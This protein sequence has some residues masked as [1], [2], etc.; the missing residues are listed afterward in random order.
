MTRPKVFAMSRSID[1][2]S[3][4]PIQAG[5]VMP[6][7]QPRRFD[8]QAYDGGP[9]PVAG[10]DLPVIVDLA[11][12]EL[13]EAMPLLIDHE[14]T[15][16]ATLGSTD[17]IENNGQSMRIA[18][19]VTATS[20][21][22]VGVVDQFDKGQRW[23][24]SIGVRVGVLQEIQAGQIVVVNKQSFRGPVLVA[25]HSQMFETSVLPAGA[26]WT[27]TVN[28]AA[29]AARLLKG[30][31]TM[32]TF[33][34]WLASL[35]VD[36]AGLDDNSR[37]ALTLGYDAMQN[38]QPTPPPT[39]PVAVPAGAP[40]VNQPNQ[41]PM[42]QV[43]ASALADIRAKFDADMLQS[44]REKY[45][46]ESERV[47]KIELV[48]AAF[49]LIKATAVRE[50]WD[51][52]KTENAVLKEQAKTKAPDG[53]VRGGRKE[54]TSQVIEAAVCLSRK[55]P[56]TEKKF[57][58][59]TLQAAH[60]QFRGGI[61]LQ[62][63]LLHAACQ[64]GYDA[65]P[66]EKV[67]NN[68]RGILKAAFSTVSLSGILSN[69]ANKELLAGYEADTQLMLWKEIAQVK[70]VSDFK[71]VTAYRMLDSM[72]YEELGAGGKIK[73][74][75]VA[76]E[77]YTRQAKT[78]AKMF[79]LTRTDI[80]NDDLGAFD[81]LRK[82]LGMGAAT[83]LSDVF[84][85]KFMSNPSSFFGTG[86]L[87]YISGSTT[88]LGTDGVGLQLGL[89]A[90]RTMR[91][92]T[93]D[94]SKR[95]GGEPEILLVPTELSAVAEQIYRNQNFGGGTT[96]AN[97]NIYANKYKPVVVPWLSDSSFAGYSAT[98]WYLFRNPARYAPMTVSFLN[99]QEQPTVESADADFD[100]LGVEFRGYHD[101]GCDVAE[102]L[103]GVKS[104]GAA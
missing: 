93:T 32:P 84:W 72:T 74:G 25:R 77:S 31:A 36:P 87:N 99:G 53:F 35:G 86:N 7:G 56:G 2:C 92:P 9:L 71:T 23:Q 94:G 91:S 21:K 104:K 83:K 95:I 101:F 48:A 4:I 46:K 14:A 61:G 6:N 22:A 62:Q 78:Y 24:A 27:T 15:V 89:N 39:A 75:T 44:S 68:L 88:N 52:V 65:S 58:D 66:G 76:E 64:N 19:L 70:S 97:A 90:F 73:S 81:D 5:A 96:I 82:R 43:S 17:L 38:P 50:G 45:A 80:I 42:P 85:T 1:L 34:E 67:G 28:L 26:D 30:T 98:A 57:N 20:Q 13:P 49:P 103:A 79:S 29:R 33:E 63:M 37:A 8:I 60:D 18:G 69:I 102:Y 47:Q 40:M 3:G 100:T 11:T 10:F 55:I 41:P 51:E 12:L 16:E 59:Q 54:L